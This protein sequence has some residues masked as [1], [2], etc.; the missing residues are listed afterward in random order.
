MKTIIVL[1]EFQT[2]EEG[3][4]FFYRGVQ[5]IDGGYRLEKRGKYATRYRP[6][7]W[8]GLEDQMRERARAIQW[9][10]RPGPEQVND[11]GLNEFHT[12]EDHLP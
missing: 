5:A 3:R 7:M 10:H 4:P 12:M 6:V 2:V 9:K 1:L 11:V 8:C